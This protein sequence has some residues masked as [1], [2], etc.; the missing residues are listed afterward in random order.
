M[1]KEVKC[2]KC[3]KMFIPAPQ[4]ALV[5]G[6]GMYCSCTCFLHRK[7]GVKGRSPNKE[8]YKVLQYTKDG[9]Y[10]KTYESAR[11]AAELL[12]VYPN[13]VATACRQGN[14]YRGFLWKYAKD[15]EKER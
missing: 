4:H 12:G 2:A 3:K 11:Q 1:F 8:A 14:I 6:R 13:S 5:D 7:D 15:V 10:I 9:E